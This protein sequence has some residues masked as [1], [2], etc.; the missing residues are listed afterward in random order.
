MKME[1]G[2]SIPT[3]PVKKPQARA[4][5]RYV[6]A[7]IEGARRGEFGAVGIDGSPLQFISGHGVTS[8][9]S[10][11]ETERIRPERRHLAAHREVLR[12]LVAHEEAVL[13]I[14][15]GTIAA[16]PDEIEAMLARNRAVL[17]RRLRRVAGTVEMGL[18][19]SW[20]VNNIFDH[21][22][23]LKPE[24]RAARDRVFG[25]HR[26][27][28]QDEQ[29]ELGRTFERLL[30]E[31]RDAHAG[32]VEQALATC[33]A[34]IKRHPPRDEREVMNLACLIQRERRGEFE[35]AV[36]KAASHFDNSLAFDYSGPW[37]PHSFAEMDI[38]VRR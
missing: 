37:A 33:C 9:V 8:V 22:I 26:Q 35:A 7:I 24:L 1:S 11:I 34:E 29:I 19:V 20:D 17:A 16:G 4:A 23:S 36:F 15:F 31:D 18:R 10:A 2:T 3:R 38:Q 30:A 13:P 25:R 21:F 6:Y 27:P 12:Q 32:I 5:R 28:T 14:C